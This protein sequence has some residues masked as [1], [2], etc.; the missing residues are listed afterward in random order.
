MHHRD[1]NLIR[2]KA[3]RFRA[4]GYTYKQIAHMQPEPK[5]SVRALRRAQEN[6]ASVSLAIRT[7]RKQ[8]AER[9]KYVLD[10]VLEHGE[11]P[12]T[13]QLREWLYFGTSI[14][15]LRAHYENHAPN[16]D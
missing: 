9:Q 5:Q 2:Y 13:L 12:S 14:N 3:L 7:Y 11:W 1:R 8:I 16:K 10:L 6:R 15:Q 4:Q